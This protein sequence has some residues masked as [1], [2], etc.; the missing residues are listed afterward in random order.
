MRK[1][2][3]SKIIKSVPLDESTDRQIPSEQ[4]NTNQYFSNVV[5]SA[6]IHTCHTNK[7]VSFARHVNISNMAVVCGTIGRFL[8]CYA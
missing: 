3:I 7:A 5:T 2:I 1:Q 4:L 6:N 8:D